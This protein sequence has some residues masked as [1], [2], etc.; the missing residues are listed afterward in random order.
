MLLVLPVLIYG[1]VSEPSERTTEG[2]TGKL[3][4]TKKHVSRHPR[5][6]FDGVLERY[7]PLYRERNLFP[8]MQ[9][10]VTKPGEKR[11]P[12]LAVY[13]D[14]VKQGA[15]KEDDAQRKVARRLDKLSSL[16]DSYEPPGPPVRRHGACVHYYK[17][18]QN[19]HLG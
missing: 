19:D 5:P 12:L 15:L 10:F 2:I 16:L 8:P 3:A 1:N 9:V 11:R 4:Q 13:D 6:K 14:L 18:V 17:P 7:V